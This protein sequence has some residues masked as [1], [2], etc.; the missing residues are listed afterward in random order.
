MQ[1]THPSYPKNKQIINGNT[2]LTI[3]LYLPF[4][5]L[6]PNYYATGLNPS[7]WMYH[8]SNGIRIEPLMCSVSSILW[9]H[10]FFMVLRS[11]MK[12]IGPQRPITGIYSSGV[13]HR[14]WRIRAS[15]PFLKILMLF[16]SL[17]TIKRIISDGLSSGIAFKHHLSK[18]SWTLWMRNKILI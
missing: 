16:R 5:P 11:K 8:Y 1:F 6:F 2:N 12:E 10:N 18:C 17:S 15:N 3:T 13:E 7:P 14:Q 4:D 9:V